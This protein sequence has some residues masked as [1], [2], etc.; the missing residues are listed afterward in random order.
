MRRRA[1]TI[2]ITDSRRTSSARSSAT[3][4]PSSTS[5][6]RKSISSSNR[7]SVNSTGKTNTVKE[8]NED[9]AYESPPVKHARTP[10]RRRSSNASPLDRVGRTSIP[11]NAMAEEEGYFNPSYAP[12]I[13]SSV[14]RPSF[15][16]N[17]QLMAPD[18]GFMFSN[19][20]D[21]PT[22]PLGFPSIQVSPKNSPKP[23]VKS[24]HSNNSLNQNTNTPKSR[25]SSL[26][27]TDVATSSKA[28]INSKSPKVARK[29]SAASDFSPAKKQDGNDIALKVPRTSS[30]TKKRSK[31]I[32]KEKEEEIIV[33][34]FGPVKTP[35]F[36][37]DVIE[38]NG[39]YI[40]S[41]LF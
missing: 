1:T 24:K 23:A 34:P 27:V 9:E 40:I 22:S 12:S 32:I 30:A 33:Y 5:S 26:A 8:E 7:K 17:S 37:R 29:N 25:R 36:V 19:F 14:R 4:K 3:D 6:S 2:S 35:I 11:T 10:L 16:L 20:P 15:N 21:C 28:S 31:S 39:N 13:I 38:I 18:P 41:D